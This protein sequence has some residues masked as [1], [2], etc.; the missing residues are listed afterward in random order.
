M[1]IAHDTIIQT[2]L[3]RYAAFLKES[4][5]IE[6]IDLPLAD[7]QNALMFVSDS[8]DGVTPDNLIPNYVEDHVWAL[9]YVLKNFERLPNIHDIL[10]IHRRVMR[11]SRLGSMIGDFRRVL[12]HVSG[13]FCPNPASVPYMVDSWCHLLKVNSHALQAHKKFEII[14][15]FLDGNGRVGRL[16]WLWLRLHRTETIGPFLEISGYAGESFEDRRQ[17]YYHDLRNE[18]GVTHVG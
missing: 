10:E 8:E 3:H 6:G 12:V 16:L 17:N 15:P 5:L 2:G 13:E 4:D 14:H 11:H 1:T 7:Y 18:R 9:A